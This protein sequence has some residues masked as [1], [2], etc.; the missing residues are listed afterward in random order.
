MVVVLSVIQKCL[1]ILSQNY[2]IEHV[3]CISSGPKSYS[4]H[5]IIVFSRGV[6]CQGYMI[7]VIVAILLLSDR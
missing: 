3:K 2:S 4:G 5:S 1:G 6:L 7:C